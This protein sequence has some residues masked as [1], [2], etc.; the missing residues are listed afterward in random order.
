MQLYKHKNTHLS[1][2]RDK[3]YSSELSENVSPHRDALGSFYLCF[4]VE[5]LKS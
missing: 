3:K 5:N 1:L 2:K 4:N